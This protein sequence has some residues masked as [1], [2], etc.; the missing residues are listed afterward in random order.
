[1]SRVWRRHNRSNSDMPIE[2]EGLVS[3]FSNISQSGLL[4]RTSKKIDEM[5]LLD[6]KFQLPQVEYKTVDEGVWIE[7]SGVVVRCEK[8][9]NK[10]AELPGEM[11]YEVAIFFDQISERYR[12][13]LARHV[14]NAIEGFV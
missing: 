9:D 3:S 4:C 13:L 8:K 5:T 6:I 14:D 11:A 2:I 12:S 7:C 10:N 1:M